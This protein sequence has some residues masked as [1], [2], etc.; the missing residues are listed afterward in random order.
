M[1][2]K[3]NAFKRLAD[4]IN[5][6]D[7]IGNKKIVVLIDGAPSLES[8]F[9]KEMES[10]RWMQ[11]VDTFVLDIFHASEYLWEAG[12]ALY[13]ERNPERQIWVKQK[14]LVILQ[15]QVGRVIG[16]LR[17]ILT[18]NTRNLTT[19]RIKALKKTITYFNNYKHMMRYDEYLKKGYPVWDRSS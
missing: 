9:I 7:P 17:Q 12:T 8:K 16:G 2:G 6:R 18:K 5:L 13:G 14:L 15:G 3:K 19:S 1:D 10:R 11:R 4:Q